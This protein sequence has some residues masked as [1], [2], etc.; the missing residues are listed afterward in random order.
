[1]LLNTWYCKGYEDHN[2]F[3]KDYFLFVKKYDNYYDAYVVEESFAKNGDRLCLCFS[4]RRVMAEETRDFA[5]SKS[6]KNEI[7]KLLDDWPWDQ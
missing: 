4:R 3:W 5:L 7:K 1:M 6:P 2:V